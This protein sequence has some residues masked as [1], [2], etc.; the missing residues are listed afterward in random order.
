MIASPAESVSTRL[1]RPMM[2]REGM[3]KTRKT[4][5]FLL[6]MEVISPLRRVTTSMILLA[7]SSGRFTVSCSTGSCF[8]PSIS[9]MITWGCP[10]CNSYPSRRMVSINTERCNTPRPNTFHESAESVG[11]TRRARF[12]SSSRSN[13]SWTWREVT[14]LPSLPKKGEL[15]MVKSIDIVGSSMAMVGRASGVAASAIVSP[16]SK[17][18]MPI[19]AQMSPDATAST[20]LRPKPSKTSISLIFDRTALPSRLQRTMSCPSRSSPRWTRP[21]AIRPTY[22]E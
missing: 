7:L 10:T 2:P 3:L 22:L 14:N 21:T 19:T 9:L 20:F 16:I 11:S 17:P 4:R 12:L 15:L 13:R 18:S 6:S 1:L 8:T 5:P